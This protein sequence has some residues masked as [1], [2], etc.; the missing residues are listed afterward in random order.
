MARPDP[1]KNRIRELNKW[2]ATDEL[3]QVTFDMGHE[4][5]LTWD[6]PAA[7]VCVVRAVKQDGTIQERAYRQAN[8]AKR[9]M[10]GLLMNDDDYI[11]MTGNAVLDTQTEIPWT[12]VTYPRFLTDSATTSTMIQARWC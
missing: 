7:Y 8:A 9:Y 2:E 1:F 4:A 3:T 10:K 12:H 11:V 5:A 6:L